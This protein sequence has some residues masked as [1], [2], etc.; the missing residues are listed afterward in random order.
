MLCDAIGR[1][2]KQCITPLFVN[3]MDVADAF[4]S[5]I[6]EKRRKTVTRDGGVFLPRHGR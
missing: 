3:L 1:Q 4:Y 6:P 2:K 5:I